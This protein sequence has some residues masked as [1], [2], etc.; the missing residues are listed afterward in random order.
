MMAGV[1]AVGGTYGRNLRKSP[2]RGTEFRDVKSIDADMAYRTLK[3]A[4]EKNRSRSEQS[5][6]YALEQKALRHQPKTP[7][8]VKL[9]SLCY[10]IASDYGRSALRPLALLVILMTSF[11]LMYSSQLDSSTRF[12]KTEQLVSITIIQTIK[13]F[14]AWSR[15]G[16]SELKTLFKTGILNIQLLAALV[17]VPPQV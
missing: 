1:S 11:Y 7:N 2:F 8:W 5:M 4:M 6:F 17:S 13:P 14:H 10:E 3:L 15:H 12:L 16:K 9:S